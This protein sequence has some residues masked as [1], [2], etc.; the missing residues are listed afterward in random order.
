MYE[1]GT[2]QTDN[3]C[4]TVLPAYV[5]ALNV[6]KSQIP[7]NATFGCS[8]NKCDLFF[9]T[10]GCLPYVSLPMC[11]L[12]PGP[13]PVS[14]PEVGPINAQVP[15]LPS[16]CYVT[17]AGGTDCAYVLGAC[18]DAHDCLAVL[19]SYLLTFNVPATEL[20][21]NDSYGCLTSNKCELAFPASGCLSGISLPMCKV[22]PACPR[23]LQRPGCNRR[24][25]LRQ[26][27]PATFRPL[28]R[29]HPLP[30]AEQPQPHRSLRLSMA[31]H[32]A[33]PPSPSA[34]RPS[35]ELLCSTS[36]A[37]LTLAALAL[38]YSW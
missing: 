14:V 9:P 26:H 12:A 19:D 25:P 6:T 5:S 36:V 32:R 33:P 34:A 4:E 24:Q 16:D 18:Q 38:F 17:N 7:S 21:A 2:C 11:P 30:P 23:P 28:S 29:L 15:I 37:V 35:S 8:G 13:A 27:H 20:P 3:D 31:C 10:N 1:L 22:A